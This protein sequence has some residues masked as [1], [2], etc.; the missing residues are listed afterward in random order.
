M[1]L[2]GN[3]KAETKTTRWSEVRLGDSE[4]RPGAI[5][6]STWVMMFLQMICNYIYVYDDIIDYIYLS[7]LYICMLHH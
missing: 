5:P 1:M 4:V 6:K 7:F 2:V 3:L